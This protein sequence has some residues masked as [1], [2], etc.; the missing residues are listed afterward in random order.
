MLIKNKRLAKAIGIWIA[1]IASIVG[2]LSFVLI[3]QY[4]LE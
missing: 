1:I 4:F 2:W 3:A